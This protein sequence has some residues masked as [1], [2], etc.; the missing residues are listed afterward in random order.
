MAKEIAIG[1]LAKISKA[2]QH[3]LLAAFVASLVLGVGL[4]LSFRFIK[5]ISYNSKVISAEDAAIDNYSNV[6]KATGICK[7]PRGSTYSSDE[8]KKCDPSSI[9]IAE[10]PG[11]LRANIIENL[12]AN[13]A[14]NSVPKED[15]ASCI[16]PLTQKSY[17]YEEL[18]KIYNDAVGSD[19]LNAASQLMQNCS[20]LR[21]IPDALPAF[22]NEE[23]MLASVNKLFNLSNWVPE[24]LSPAGEGVED[25]GSGLNVLGV[26]LSM[27]TSTGVVKDFLNNLDRSIREFHVSN[28]SI[29]WSEDSS[30]NFSAQATAYYMDET[31]IN[32][33][34]ETVSVEG[35]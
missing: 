34:T 27:E 6:I 3:I 15:N 32:E 16:N 5:Q 31:A 12:A 33:T 21:V 35:Q 29:E 7:A 18:N 11:T 10:I 4:S 28:M 20:A 24:S 13:Q 8:L 30:L 26:N 25:D 9:E 1:K 22:R 23:A 17:T 2:E 19:S 14:L